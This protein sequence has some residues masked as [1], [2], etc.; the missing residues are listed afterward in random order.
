M[1]KA[2]PKILDRN[3]PPVFVYGTLR[4]GQKNYGR[5]LEGRTCREI[6]AEA[7]GILFYE[8]DGGHPY[9]I[10]GEGK[11]AGELMFLA[12]D[13]YAETLE[14]LDALENYDPNREEESLYI[15]RR[16]LVFPRS[17]GVITAWMYFWNRQPE[18]RGRR[19]TSG[20]FLDSTPNGHSR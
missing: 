19:I 5:F 10:P 11:V 4:R 13:T 2:G 16:C 20:D 14:Q 15:R 7:P 17:G 12:S 9:V 6:E 8:T 1:R 18:I 3:F